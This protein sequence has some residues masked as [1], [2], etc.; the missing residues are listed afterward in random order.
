MYIIPFL[1]TVSNI[2][3]LILF[4]CNCKQRIFLAKLL[5]QPPPP[6][7]EMGARSWFGLPRSWR[8]RNGGTLE[9]KFCTLT[10]ER[11][12]RKNRNA[13][14]AFLMKFVLVLV[15]LSPV[16][17]LWY[18]FDPVWLSPD[19]SRFPSTFHT[20]VYKLLSIW[21][22]ASLMWEE[23]VWAE[24]GADSSGRGQFRGER[25]G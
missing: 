22:A 11:R 24:W 19:I 18:Y 21:S 5:R 4:F 7:S 17:L 23:R 14:F 2:R 13:N 6:P 3:I 15:D 12:T 25:L 10:R 8:F 1:W 16:E 20:K 9:S